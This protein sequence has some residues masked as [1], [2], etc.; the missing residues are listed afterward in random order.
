MI[1]YDEQDQRDYYTQ[2][3]YYITTLAGLDPQLIT[4]SN[5]DLVRNSIMVTFDEAE[6]RK[7]IIELGNLIC[8]SV[9]FGFGV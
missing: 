5:Y 8:F 3:C 6:Q 2:R 4:E 7:A 9:I 1:P